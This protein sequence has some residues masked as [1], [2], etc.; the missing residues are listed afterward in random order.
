MDQKQAE[1]EMLH[2]SLVQLQ[3]LKLFQI[4]TL[5]RKRV[6]F[7]TAQRLSEERAQLHHKKNML[8]KCLTAWHTY[9]RLQLRKTLLQRQGVWFENTR[10]LSL[11]YA[12]WR[13][14]V[15]T[16]NLLYIAMYEHMKYTS[17]DQLIIA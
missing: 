14:Q 11:T 9:H 3:R 15:G 7:N 17:V 6:S 5:W 1:D 2:E 10:L 4:F 12:R 8:A 16:Q 13:V